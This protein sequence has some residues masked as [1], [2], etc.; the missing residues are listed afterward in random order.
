MDGY[1]GSITLFLTADDRI[2]IF[3][4]MYQSIPL[5]NFI[6]H[7]ESTSVL[8][9]QLPFSLLAIQKRFKGLNDRRIYV[10]TLG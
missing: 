3:G 7:Q 10:F 4:P 8:E 5:Q 6:R 2:L 1:I 9:T